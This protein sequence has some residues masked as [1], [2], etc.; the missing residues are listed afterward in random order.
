MV[1]ASLVSYA[2]TRFVGFEAGKILKRGGASRSESNETIAGGNR[3]LEI[4]AF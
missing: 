4:S 3:S 2:S 1:A